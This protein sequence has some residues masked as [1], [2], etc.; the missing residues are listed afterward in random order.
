MPVRKLTQPDIW[1]DSKPRDIHDVGWLATLKSPFAEI[2]LASAK[3]K[4]Q[5][6]GLAVDRLIKLQNEA[7]IKSKKKERKK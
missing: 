7:E 4:E 1:I 3:T 2:P 6:Y 5:A